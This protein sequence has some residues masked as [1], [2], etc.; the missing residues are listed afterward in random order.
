VSG[1]VKIVGTQN[2]KDV[3]EGAVVDQNSAEDRLLRFNILGLKLF[4]GNVFGRWMQRVSGIKNCQLEKPGSSPRRYLNK[5]I[6]RLNRFGF[7]LLRER[8]LP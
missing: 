5:G 4:E 6:S 2:L 3:D 7:I 8:L 1:F